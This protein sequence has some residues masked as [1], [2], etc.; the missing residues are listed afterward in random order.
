[1]DV[2]D[3]DGDVATADG[4]IFWWRSRGCFFGVLKRQREIKELKLSKR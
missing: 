3:T 2:R 4:V 1:M